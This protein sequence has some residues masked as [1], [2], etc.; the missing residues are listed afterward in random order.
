V[1]QITVNHQWLCATSRLPRQLLLLF[2]RL[3]E[4]V[5]STLTQLVALAVATGWRFGKAPKTTMYRM[6][7]RATSYNTATTKWDVS[8]VS[9]FQ[10]MF[11]EA[12][13]FNGDSS[14]A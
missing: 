12:F 8:G 11:E 1:W 9:S 5:T 14:G 2:G 3:R 10:S 6:F 4:P 7:F 13:R